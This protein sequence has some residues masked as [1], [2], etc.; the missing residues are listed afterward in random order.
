VQAERL[1]RGTGRRGTGR[2]WTGR[3]W[4]GHERRVALL[5]SSLIV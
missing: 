5:D 1:A 4:M 3:S 2:G